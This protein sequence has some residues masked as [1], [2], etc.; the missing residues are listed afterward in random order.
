M[1]PHAPNFKTCT[2]WEGGGYIIS[3]NKQ[4]LTTTQGEER[5]STTQGKEGALITQGKE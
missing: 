3:I 5:A 1:T 2:W 4:L